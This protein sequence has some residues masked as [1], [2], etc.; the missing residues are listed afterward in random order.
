[1][2]KLT[3]ASRARHHER[4]FLRSARH[5]ASRAALVLLTTMTG[6][7]AGAQ[8]P[9]VDAALENDELRAETFEAVLRVTDEH[10]EYVD[11]L[12][13]ATLRHPVTLDRFL[14]NTASGLREEPLAR[15]TARRLAEQ[16]EAL[17]LVLITTLDAISDKPPSLAAVSKAMAERPHVA[18]L[19]V[20]QREDAVKAV[21]HA[22][23]QEVQK[24]GRARRAF[25]VGLQENSGPMAR[26]IV[27]NPETL[28]ALLRGMSEAGVSVGKRELDALVDAL[29]SAE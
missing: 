20:V 9:A 11:E 10:P 4:T 25:L 22:L 12:F 15:H 13:R 29:P 16:P 19:A 6:C 2:A 5:V 26:V 21:L 18:A 3:Q 7:G 28:A 8:R 23:V 24:D 17:R 1:M 14:R 27:T